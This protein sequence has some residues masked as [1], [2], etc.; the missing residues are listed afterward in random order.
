MA[1]TGWADAEV[2]LDVV[3]ILLS[4]GTAFYLYALAKVL[5]GGVLERG[6]TILAISPVLLALSALL[7]MLTA[8]GFGEAYGVIRDLNRIIFILVF[9]IGARSIV[10]AWRKLT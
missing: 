9:F 3:G 1:L 10:V 4:L 2:V 7:D 8:L 6:M 5:R